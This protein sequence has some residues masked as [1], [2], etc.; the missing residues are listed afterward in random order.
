MS[1]SAG[2]VGIRHNLMQLLRPVMLKLGR[3]DWDF[4]YVF[5]E[6]HPPAFR[7]PVFFCFLLYTITANQEVRQW[8][9]ALRI[10]RQTI[11]NRKGE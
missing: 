3:Q 7:R 6:L 2:H 8:T 1:W 10:T 11:T 4:L 9:L 5:F